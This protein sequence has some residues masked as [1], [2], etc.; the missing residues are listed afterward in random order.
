VEKDRLEAVKQHLR[1]QF[2][3]SLNN[4]EAI[5]IAVSRSLR[6]ERSPGTI[7]R[8]YD[9]YARISPADIQRVANKYFAANNR[10]IVT[11]TGAGASTPGVRQP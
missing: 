11:L 3:L 4:T 5:A 10:T 9:L 1:Y 7:E 6:A 2:S 8:L